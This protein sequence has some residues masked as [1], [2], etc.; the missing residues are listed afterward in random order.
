[1]APDVD[2]LLDERG[3]GAN[4][5]LRPKSCLPEE[6]I[7]RTAKSEKPKLIKP[8]QSN[9]IS[10]KPWLDPTHKSFKIMGKT[11][12]RSRYASAYSE[13]SGF[14]PGQRDVATLMYGYG[15]TSD[16][17][18]ASLMKRNRK[19]VYRHKKACES[20]MDRPEVQRELEKLFVKFG[21]KRQTTQFALDHTR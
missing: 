8:A 15:M 18:I 13:L 2:T 11:Y 7:K 4:E 6:G 21:V 3:I 16:T 5:D 10:N 12:G 17:A 9:D 1:M 20:K 14:T 19:T